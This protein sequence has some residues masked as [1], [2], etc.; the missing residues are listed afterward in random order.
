MSRAAAIVIALALLAP[1]AQAQDS[2]AWP[3]R[4]VRIVVPSSPGGGTDIYARLLA[5]GLTEGLKQTFV[6]DNRPGAAGNIG[7]EIAARS[8]PDGYTFLVSSN[9]SIAINP[10]LYKNL[11]FSAERD[12]APVARG[13]F[14]PSAFTSHPSVPT[15]TLPALVAL[16]KREP[17]KLPYGSAGIGSPPHLGVRM[18]EEA[19]G[20]RFIHV[21]Y[22]GLGQAVQGLLRGEIGF[23]IADVAT[24][25]PYI[26]S[27][28][29]LALAVT[30][31]V[32]Q[33]PGVPTQASAGYPGIEVYTSFSV[34]VPAGT[35]PAIIQRLSAEIGKAMKTPAI[36]ERIEGL[37]FIPVFDT[38]DAFAASLKKERQMWADVIRRNNI[39]AE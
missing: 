29:L 19:S 1:A 22:K 10:S 5:Q 20:A 32:P 16:G 23:M 2:A 24:V 39:T 11:S 30:Q 36:K 17:G 7:A 14:A 18:V 9:S 3:A 31:P 27:K 21:P 37:A 28:R 38:P 15:K 6:V 34:S 33:L 12:L 13:V 26:R 25:L 4:P 35:P 8:A